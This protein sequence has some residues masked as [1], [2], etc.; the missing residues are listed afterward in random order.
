MEQEEEKVM[1]LRHPLTL[2]KG[3]D[4]LT[5]TELKLRE[6]KGGELEKATREDTNVGVSLTL[7][8]L[9]TGIPRKAV[10]DIGQRDL[11]EASD[12]LGGFTDDGPPTGP[13]PLPT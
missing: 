9:I 10:E 1:V 7:I 5:Y 4:A 8:A 2:G 13:T 3:P 12:Y 11:R 6:P